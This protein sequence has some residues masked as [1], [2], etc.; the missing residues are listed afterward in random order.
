VADLVQATEHLLTEPPSLERDREIT[1]EVGNF[2]EALIE[3]YQED[4]DCNKPL[5]ALTCSLL[6]AGFYA[7]DTDEIAQTLITKA[8]EGAFESLLKNLP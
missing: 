8:E 4:N 7:C 6:Q 1:K 2:L 5:E 3:G